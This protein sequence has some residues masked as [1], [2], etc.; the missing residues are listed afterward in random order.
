MI[1]YF[2]LSLLA[3]IRKEEHNNMNNRS[4]ENSNMSYQFQRWIITLGA[5]IRALYE[6]LSSKD[7][8][9]LCQE[10]ACC[11]AELEQLYAYAE[12]HSLDLLA[13]YHPFAEIEKYLLLIHQ[14][15]ASKQTDIE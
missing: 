13:Y 2:N 10:T 5:Q 8:E 14:H 15:L 9:R 7:R 3:S 4:I 12:Q 1:F 6:S 11:Q